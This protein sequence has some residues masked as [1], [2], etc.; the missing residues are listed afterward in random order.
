M[1]IIEIKRLRDADKVTFGDQVNIDGY[2][3][4][5]EPPTDDKIDEFEADFEKAKAREVA[6]IE[7]INK[8]IVKNST[9]AETTGNGQAQD[10]R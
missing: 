3:N 10:S 6:V 9:E 2:V 5:P 7:R 1:E 4:Y 8:A